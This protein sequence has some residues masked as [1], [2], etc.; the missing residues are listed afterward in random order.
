MT[1]LWVEGGRRC[2]RAADRLHKEGPILKS[3]VEEAPAAVAANARERRN[4]RWASGEPSGTEM[5]VK[6]KN[7]NENKEGRTQTR[8][9]EG[10][11]K[12]RE[13][14]IHPTKCKALAGT[15]GFLSRTDHRHGSKHL[16]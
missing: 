13:R 7:K 10:D 11:G 14:E 6:G 12:K 3:E 15:H 1:D 2:A 16:A 9:H 5:G 4:G 8:A